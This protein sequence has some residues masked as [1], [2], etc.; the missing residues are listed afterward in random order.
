MARTKAEVA[1]RAAARRKAAAELN[2]RKKANSTGLAGAFGKAFGNFRVF[3][4]AA[5]AMK[6][7]TK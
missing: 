2:K 4:N 7:A 6:K 5:G 1:S 3:R